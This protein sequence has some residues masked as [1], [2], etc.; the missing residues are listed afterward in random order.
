MQNH[1]RFMILQ[2]TIKIEI[3]P[4]SQITMPNYWNWFSI[5]QIKATDFDSNLWGKNDG[6][7]LEKESEMT[8]EIETS[9]EPPSGRNIELSTA[10]V[11]E[12]L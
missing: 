12:R 1:G 3:G 5:H 4:K 7:F 10:F 11:A 8:G 2:K 9:G 6:V